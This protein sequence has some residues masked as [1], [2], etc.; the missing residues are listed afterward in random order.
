MKRRRRTQSQLQ[1]I[2][3]E[4]QEW[5]K[6]KAGKALSTFTHCRTCIS[7]FQEYLQAKYRNTTP[8]G[9]FLDQLD[10]NEELPR[11]KRRQLAETEING[12]I[13]YLQKKGLAS[14]T[15]IGYVS[16]ITQ[17]LAYKHFSVNA[18][19][20]NTPKYTPV[21]ENR[22]H[23]WTLNEMREF[24]DKARSVRD[25]AFIVCCFQSGLSVE[26][27]SCPRLRGHSKRL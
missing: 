14:G 8:I 18:N 19:L 22:K 17:F 12:F 23:A 3:E 5:L 7:Y 13:N 6:N 24:V 27:P 2:E 11:R 21:K 26:D 25:K 9:V 16:K 15:I 4:A 20:L 1:N 10:A